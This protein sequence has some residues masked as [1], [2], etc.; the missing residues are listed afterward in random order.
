MDKANSSDVS[1]PDFKNL[2]EKGPDPYLVLDKSF[3]IIAV[4]DAYLN[5]SMTKRESILGKGIFD[6]FPD[7][8]DDPAAEG[9]RN[10]K[11]SLERVLKNLKPDAMA[12]QKYDIRKPESEGGGF[13][14]RF[15]SPINTPVLGPHEEVVC[16]VHRVEDVTEFV[17]LKQQGLESEK[18]TEALREKALRMETEVFAR[19]REVAAT[20]AE[21]KKANDEL[22]VL[23]EKTKELDELKTN[24]FAN[25]SHEIRTPMNAILGLTYLLKRHDPTPE[26]DERLDKIATASK[27]LLAIINDILD[28]SKIEAGKFVLEKA[29]FPVSAILDHTRSLLE[30]AAEAKGLH[31]LVEYQDMPVWLVGDQTRLRQA[32]LNYASNA[33]KFTEHGT[34]TL[35]GKILKD[36]GQEVLI[37]FEVVDTGI[38]IAPEKIPELFQAFKQVDA[39]TTRK[40][41]GTGLGLAI[42]QRLSGLMGGKA[43]VKSKVGVGSTFWFTACLQRGSPIETLKTSD[44]ESVLKTSHSGAYILLV[45]DDLINQEVAKSLLTE[46][47]MRVDVAGNGMQAVEQV[48]SNIYD[49]V[50]MDIQMPVMDGITATKV[51]RQIPGREMLPILAL[52]ANVFEEYRQRCT[53]AGMNDF[54]SKPVEPIALFS[55]ILKWLP[56]SAAAENK[57][58][59]SVYKPSATVDPNKTYLYA[60]LIEIE[61]LDINRGLTSVSG[62]IEK[63]WELLKDF[64]KLHQ[65]DTENLRQLLASNQTSEPI[66]IAH[67]LKGSAGTLGLNQ[68]RSTSAMLEALLNK[69]VTDVEKHINEIDAALKRLQQSIEAIAREETAETV[70]PNLEAALKTL[71]HI[72]QQLQLNDFKASLSFR[73]NRPLIRASINNIQMAGLEDAIGNYDFPKALTIIKETID[74]LELNDKTVK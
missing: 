4:N 10:L 38:G 31:I 47:G 55:T 28:F 62:K 46:A 18:L 23:Y 70:Q 37:K 63:Y 9:V 53:E 52:T 39:S 1:V 71:Q 15:W 59:T 25:M 36:M 66:R 30:D 35:R 49:L 54:V 2:F 50:L 22:K 69:G 3:T 6:V 20:S 65:L 12:V 17:K 27:H 33:L 61:G 40:Y 48:K 29:T 16:I 72:R 58:L 57:S 67:T 26:Q 14:E 8:P 60:R 7:N 44:A 45:E 24:F 74:T 68:I 11:V 13:E 64:V 43:G 34:I 19:A 21:L 41:G 56:A 5:A 73:E 42:T 32:L 51:L